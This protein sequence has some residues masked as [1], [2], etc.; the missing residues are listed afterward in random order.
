MGAGV[1]V[2]RKRDSFDAGVAECPGR[3]ID[4]IARLRASGTYPR[5]K[6]AERKG[7]HSQQKRSAPDAVDEQHDAPILPAVPAAVVTSSR[8]TSRAVA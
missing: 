1:L 4:Q 3:L 6:K 7:G 8:P 2:R 5:K